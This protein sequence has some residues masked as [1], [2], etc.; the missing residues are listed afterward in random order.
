[1]RISISVFSIAALVLGG[2]FAANRSHADSNAI[3]FETYA[4]GTINAQDGWKAIG[5]YDQSVV[6][7]T[8]GY[9]SFGTQTFRIS[10]AVTSGGFG[11]QTF[12]KPLADSVGETASTNGA[13]PV[14][15]K[16][17]H[18]EMQ[19]DMASTQAAMQPG[20]HVSLSPD[21]GDGSRMS[22]LRFEDG[23]AGIN[24]FFDDVQ[25]ATNPANFVE[26]QIATDLTRTSP[27]TIK[28]TMDMLDGPSNDIVKVYIDGALVHT[29]TSWENYYVFDSESATEPTPR[30]IKTVE[31][32]ESGAATAADLG[33]GFLFDNLTL[34]SSQLAHTI[35]AAADTNGSISPVGPVSVNDS[36]DQTFTI[37]P[38]SGFHVADV[39][40]DG[41]SVGAVA[42]YTFSSV[43]LDHTIAASF[44]ANIISGGGGG[45]GGGGGSGNGILPP[46]AASTPSPASAATPVI[47]PAP[48]QVL[49][50]I[51]SADGMLVKADDIKTVFMASDGKFRPFTS[52]SVFLSRG[53][54]FSDV[55]IIGSDV[56]TAD[57]LGRAMGYPDNTLIRDSGSTIYIVSGDAKLGIPSMAVFRN[58]KLS[59]NKIIRLSSSDL[60]S[61]DDGGIA[62]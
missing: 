3:N 13:F 38:S 5:A 25:G 47:V 7:N 45:G 20:L 16:Q 51:T 40:A 42:S 49:G 22:Y 14:G 43:K 32:R 1:M 62:Q 8:Y 50:A 4:P 15:T 36:M 39:L 17:N 11:D 24:V 48:G 31:F 41:V 58:M 27:H 44:A 60:A 28:L 34:S 53:L 9:A 37:S 46:V 59:L 52:G 29:G 19:F 56:M 57:N 21:R 61:Y 12:A 2:F 35:T 33:K 10:D 55:Q 30:I 54:K 6:A 18:F 23:T 26:T